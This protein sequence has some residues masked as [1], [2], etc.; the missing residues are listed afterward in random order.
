MIAFGAIDRSEPADAP[1]GHSF[2]GAGAGGQQ[3][4]YRVLSNGPP[5]KVAD[6]NTAIPGGTGNFTSFIP[7]PTARKAFTRRASCRLSPSASPLWKHSATIC[8]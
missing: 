7:G 3:G 8:G 4:I 2:R 1:L 6:L 5:I